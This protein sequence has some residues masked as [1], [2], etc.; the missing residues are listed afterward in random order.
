MEMEKLPKVE[1][2]REVMQKRDRKAQLLRQLADEITGFGLIM[3]R[4]L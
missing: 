1:K 2:V 4:Y 3:T